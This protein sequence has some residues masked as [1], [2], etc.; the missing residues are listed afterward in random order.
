M[1]FAKNTKE[2]KKLHHDLKITIPH[3]HVIPFNLYIYICSF[4]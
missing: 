1:E 3:S 2:D 4:D